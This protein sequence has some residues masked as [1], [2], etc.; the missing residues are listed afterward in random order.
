M[1]SAAHFA[2]DDKTTGRVVSRRLRIAS[3]TIPNPITLSVILL[4]CV[5]QK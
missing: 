3:H 5:R 1:E 2:E 4:C